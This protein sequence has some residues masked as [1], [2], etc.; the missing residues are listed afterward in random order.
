[1]LARCARGVV[2]RHAPSVG[3]AATSPA[4]AVEDARRDARS[5][6]RMDSVISKVW[7][8]QGRRCASPRSGRACGAILDAARPSKNHSIMR[9][10]EGD[11]R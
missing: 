5:I 2:R 6:D 8:G 7:P 4:K 11:E 3:F 10:T 9:S 1:M